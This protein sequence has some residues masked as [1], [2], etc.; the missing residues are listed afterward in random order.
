MLRA[1]EGV[2]EPERDGEH[3]DRDR[4]E[5]DE[6]LGDEDHG[7]LRALALLGDG[8]QA[9]DLCWNVHHGPNGRTASTVAPE[10][11]RREYAPVPEEGGSMPTKLTDAQRAFLDNPYP[12]VVTT[13]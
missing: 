12:A 4:H 11:A 7:R 6:D 5:E 8:V 9:L 1:A 2:V 3:D 10:P 13:L